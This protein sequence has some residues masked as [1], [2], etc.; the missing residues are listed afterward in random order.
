MKKIRIGNDISI[1]WRIMRSGVDE[2][3]TGKDVSVRL[4]DFAG[5]DAEIEWDIDGSTVAVTFRGRNQTRAGEYTL[6]LTEN[7]G[8][9]D[10]TT[11]DRTRAFRLVPRQDSVVSDGVGGCCCNG[12]LSVE[13]V[14]LTSEL[15][16]PSLG[17]GVVRVYN[18]VRGAWGAGLDTD[19]E[20]VSVKI[21][22]DSSEIL[23]VDD[24]GLH[25]D[26][27]A[28]GGGTEPMTPDD[29]DEV[30]NGA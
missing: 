30:I 18:I 28:I 7:A 5:R 2:D 14:E 1:R 16:V 26:S 8:K 15:Q 3:F 10:M 25:I 4:Q 11:V 17:K 6:T 24:E 20:S 19:G 27:S 13:T 21:A 9:D 22:P 23:S 12:S 29:I